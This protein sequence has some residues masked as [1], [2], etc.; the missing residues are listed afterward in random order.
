[1]NGCT[2][3]PRWPAILLL[4]PYSRFLA[5]V[6]QWTERLPSKQRVAGSNPAGGILKNPCTHT[7]FRRVR[8]LSFAGSRGVEIGISAHFC[9][10]D[11]LNQGSKPLAL[12]LGAEH[13]LRID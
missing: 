1:M 6:A 4:E 3:V 9:P 8:W 11:P 7:C 2:V 10:N 12:A 13:H 5:P